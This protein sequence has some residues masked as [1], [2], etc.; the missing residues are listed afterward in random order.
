[1]G[2]F[3]NSLFTFVLA[4]AATAAQADVVFLKEGGRLEGTVASATDRE[5]VL[6][7]SQGRVSID[8]SRVSSIDY[9]RP[10]PAPR[11][12]EYRVV[13]ERPAE[14]LFEPRNQS[15]SFDFGISVPL[16]GVDF[17]ALNFS[18]VQGGT[19]SN[20]D[21]GPLVGLQY[22]YYA[23]PR[24]AWGAEVRYHSR[25]NTDSPG[26]VPFADASV[27]GD[28]LLLMGDLK[29]ALA[30]RGSVRPYVLFG[31][32]AHRTSTTIDAQPVPG[33]A[34]SDTG[35]D[36]ERRLVDGS[37]WGPALSVRLGLDFGFADP[38]VFAVEAGWTGLANAGYHPTP[39]G[40][41]LGLSST[42]GT[43]NYFTLAGRWGWSF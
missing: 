14:P 3:K 12:V 26:L 34:W 7:T 6:D 10:A 8:R 22:L 9:A 29:L 36:E 11:R 24:M 27:S 13:R 33:A 1:M 18:G 31:A 2:S 43:L 35:T 20:G 28:S 41:A 37:M 39:Q 17:S 38:A 19:A 15:L 21:V 32:G 40:Q 30:D 16:S 25:T 42:S 5:V 23:S 4:L